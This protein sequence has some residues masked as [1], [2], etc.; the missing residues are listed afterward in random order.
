[1]IQ[2]TIP[3]DKYFNYRECRELYKKLKGKIGDRRTFRELMQETFFYSFFDNQ[4]FLGCIYFYEEDNKLYVNAFAN[5]HTHLQN[6]KC[7][8]MS[9]DWFNCDIYARSKHKTAI[10]CLLKSGFKRI[11]NNLFIYERSK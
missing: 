4:K 8:K 7:F 1:M 3:K 9:L 6:L 5:R 11:D 2:V 10:L